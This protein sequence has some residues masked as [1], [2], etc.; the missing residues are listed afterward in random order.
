MKIIHKSQL[1]RE[2]SEKLK[3]HIG[4]TLSNEDREFFTEKALRALIDSIRDR[5][6]E[7][8]KVRLR[9]LGTFERV[10]TPARTYRNPKTGQPVEKPA[11][12]RLKFTADKGVF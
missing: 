2:I 11:G 7:G 9:G 4:S 10:E 5:V 6:T 3:V 8:Y 1:Q 12:Y